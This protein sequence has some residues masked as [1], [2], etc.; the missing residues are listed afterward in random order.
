M[1][2]SSSA[3][4]GTSPVRGVNILVPSSW[5][6]FDIHPA[7]RD[8]SIREVVRERVQERP[9][10][11]DSRTA[12]I[13]TLTR[14]AD[15]AWQTGVLY[16]GALADL[17]DEAPL[18]ASVT[19]AVLEADDRAD[20][21][22]DGDRPGGGAGGAGGTGGN[23]AALVAALKPVAAGRRPTDPWRRIK[24]V[25]L[26]DAGSA[27]RSEGIDDIE[28]PDDDRTVRMVLMQ[29]FVPFPGGDPRVAVISGATSQLALAE[30]MLE[31]FDGITET[32]RFV[33]ADDDPSAGSAERVS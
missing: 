3:P 5:Y 25:E 24:L 21:T 28:L 27:A 30:P 23:L 11:A 33:Y 7:T 31:L 1:T 26:P 17:S 32:F 13:R 8:A 22:A 9:E 2:V 6:E 10:L 18:T 29:T 19:I 12:L 14:T 16:F 15:E 20:G 4:S